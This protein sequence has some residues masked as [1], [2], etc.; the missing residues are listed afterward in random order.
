MKT[1]VVNLFGGPGTGKSTTCAGTFAELKLRGVNCE[2]A[3]EHAKELVGGNNTDPLKDQHYMFGMQHQIIFRLVDGTPI[4]VV[5]TDCPLLMSLVYGENL[6][7]DFKESV[8][9]A[10]NEFNNLNV[11][12]QRIKPYNPTGRVH[13]EEESLVIDGKLPRILDFLG[14][15]YHTLPADEKVFKSVADLVLA[16]EPYIKTDF[17]IPAM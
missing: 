4:E 2:M 15:E 5:V 6:P 11:F 8:V 14:E 13:T 12:L 16:T 3:I 17:A 7:N 9:K 1:L 10:Y